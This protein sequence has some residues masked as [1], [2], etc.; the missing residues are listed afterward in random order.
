MSDFDQNPQEPEAA[1]EPVEA[2]EAP[3]AEQAPPPVYEQ[4]PPPVYEQAPPPVYEQAPPPAY[5]QPAYEQP[6]YQAPPP[7]A[8]PVYGAE[9]PLHVP[10]L[11]VGILAIV[12]AFIFG[13][14]GLVLSIVGMVMAKRNK[15]TH[16]TTV[17]FVL[18]VVGLIISI[19]MTIIWVVAIAFIGAMGLGLMSL[20]GL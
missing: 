15:A 3:A 5:E 4:A 14:V 19:I 8:Q 16:K 20:A 7:Y 6:A 10:S 13:P 2:A 17:G 11:I 9:K 1:P 18:S 12:F